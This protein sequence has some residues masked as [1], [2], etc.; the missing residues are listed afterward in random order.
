MKADGE[1]IAA[2]AGGES[3]DARASVEST[4]AKVDGGSTNAKAG[5]ESTGGKAD[6]E[7]KSAEVDME[8]GTVYVSVDTPTDAAPDVTSKHAEASVIAQCGS[9]AT[10]GVAEEEQ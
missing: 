5:V 3:I 8:L 2:K 10:D 9:T 1:L 4:G 6:G 7:S